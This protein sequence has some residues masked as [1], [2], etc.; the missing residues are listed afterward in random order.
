[1]EQKLIDESIQKLV[2]TFKATY[3]DVTLCNA[4]I[5]EYVVRLMEGAEIMTYLSGANKKAVVIGALIELIK[6]IPIKN[7]DK[8]AIMAFINNGMLDKFIDL[9]IAISKNNVNLNKI[10][11]CC[12]GCN[13]M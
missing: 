10:K 11:T 7:E 13:I 4:N 8:E 6:E 2:N 12:K 1:M 9:T 5:Q 3:K